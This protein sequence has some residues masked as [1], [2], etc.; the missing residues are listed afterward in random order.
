[1]VR[2][3]L[4][5]T[6]IL[7]SGII[8]S[9]FARLFYPEIVPI[10]DGMKIT[11]YLIIAVTIIAI[12]RNVVGVV[13]YGVFGP[14][15]ISLGLTEIGNFFIGLFIIM[16]IISIGLLVRSLLEQ[17]EL[18]MSHRMAIIVIIVSATMGFLKYI[19]LKFRLDPLTFSSFI[20]ILI[21]AWIIE[22]FTRDRLESGFKPSFRRFAYTLGAIFLCYL[23]LSARE[24]MYYFIYTPEFWLFPLFINIIIGSSVRIRVSEY[25]RFKKLIKNTGS[26]EGK[27]EVLTLNVRNREYIDKYNQPHL[28]PKIT[29]L[30]VKED[31]VRS[32]VE[33]P[34]TLLIFNSYYDLKNLR[35]K[36]EVL[37]SEKSFVIKPNNSYGGRG[38][39]I[40]KR[41]S[42]KLFEKIN[43]DI[44]TLEELRH[45]IEL[46]L[47]GEYSSR[48]LPDRVFIEEFV[49]TD[50]TLAQISYKGLPDIRIIV[51]N[52]IPIIAMTRLTT[53]KSDGRANLHQGAIGGGIDLMTGK[54]TRA[55]VAHD[56]TNIIIHPDTGAKIIGEIIPFWEQILKIAVKS[57]QAVGLGYA[58]IDIVIDKER[59][60]LVMEINKRP[61]LEI[62]NANSVPLLKRLHSVEIF[63]QENRIDSMKDSIKAMKFLESKNWNLNSDNKIIKEKLP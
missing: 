14:A 48:W 31:L 59:G 35:E 17:F 22:R 58:G 34:N 5:A 27:L 3:S 25:Y 55:I 38:I 2:A 29:K 33:V 40:I 18:Q 36:L 47:D 7:F 12:L 49:N 24:L 43:G 23:L 13:T 1:M 63:L 39:S 4:G 11:F 51:F 62:Q 8:V 41:R 57:Q 10:L 6:I 28:F 61:G 42:G 30:D 15:I 53:V 9:L 21:S 44:V 46:I 16:V 50:P 26:D 19:G 45:Q 32:G 54:I 20:P 37:P 60:P 52:Q 56:N